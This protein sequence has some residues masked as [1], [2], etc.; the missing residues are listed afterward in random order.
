MAKFVIAGEANCPYYARAELLGDKL[1]INL[2]EF[3]LH[4]IVKTSGEWDSWLK[5]TCQ[6]RG[7]NHR[8]SPLVWRELIDRG[9]KGVLIGGANEFQEYAQGYYGIESQ[10]VSDDMC[11]IAKENEKCKTEID[12]EEAEF[13]AQSN[14]L[15]VC[16]T[17]ASSGVC[18]SLL[19][20]LCKGDVLGKD[21][22]LV[23]KLFDNES[24]KEYL[25]GVAM[26][27]CDLAY[28][29]SRG[30]KVE[31]NAK[32]A[33]KDCSAIILLDDIPQGEK[34]KDD[35]IKENADLFVNYAKIIDEVAL[36]SVRVLVAGSGPVNFNAYMMIKN[37]PSIPRQ[38]IVALSRLIEN[39][40]KA[41]IAERLKV[42]TACVVDL[43]IWGNPHGQ[44]YTD[45]SNSR[46]H[47]YDGAI[48]GPDSFSVSGPEMVF[49][50]K[51]LET[52]YLELVKTKQDRAE[53][54]M[55]HP[56]ASS[57][58][59]AINSTMMH[60][61][62]GSPCGQMFSLG[63]CSDGWY[64]VPKEMVF[65]Y[66]VT[67]DPKGYWC[68]VQDI[69]VTE[70]VKVKLHETIKDLESEIEVMFPR[71]KPPTP[72]ADGNVSNNQSS[73][74]E[75]ADG[76]QRLETIVEEKKETTEE[77]DTSTTEGEKSTTNGGETS[78]AEGEKT[79]DAAEKSNDDKEGEKTGEDTDKQ[80]DGD[81]TSESEKK[82]DEATPGE[83]QAP[84][85]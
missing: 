35:W 21:V 76:E 63:V 34:S 4:K 44:H 68:V 57:R 83:E 38:N 8:K 19:D 16:I 31:T 73:G 10:L 2:P 41:V 33:F 67:F 36:K 48:V 28:G 65:S 54:A 85:E 26:E 61:F 52:E 29:L 82:D 69:D 39:H 30:V 23:I 58:A 72:E 47:K 45:V 9:G 40:S 25:E 50:K 56:S 22:E 11:K 6:E 15:N 53:E 43:I 13:K 12:K 46:V 51:W 80:N 64:G 17:N 1:A 59:S 77:G 14:P 20:S 5:N 7:W 49:D 78:T 55:K 24:K 42:N 79:D 60:W 71:P 18:Y 62:S 3:K 27:I 32:D 81:K 75:K 66:P 37:A 74:D 70:E 84:S